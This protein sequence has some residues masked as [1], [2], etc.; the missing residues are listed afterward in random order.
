MTEELE[1]IALDIAISE[2]IREKIGNLSPTLKEKEWKKDDIFMPETTNNDK[3]TKNNRI[4][5][6][7]KK[8]VQDITFGLFPEHT[9]EKKEKEKEKVWLTLEE[10]GVGEK[11]KSSDDSDCSNPIQHLPKRR[12]FRFDQCFKSETE[13]EVYKDRV[14]ELLNA[15]FRPKELHEKVWIGNPAFDRQILRENGGHIS[16]L[17]YYL[18]LALAKERICINNEHNDEV[19]MNYPYSGEGKTLHELLTDGHL[20]MEVTERF[21]IG[22]RGGLAK[23]IQMAILTSCN[24]TKE[25]FKCRHKKKKHDHSCNYMVVYRP[26]EFSI[27]DACINAY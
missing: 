17:I 25:E 23:V 11:R 22:Q 3:S 8:E 18:T 19:D 24:I 16:K 14:V 10:A 1:D 12:R 5:T 26:E 2:E 20:S 6:K 9:F 21:P 4:Y 15:C 27:I 7:Y 13:M